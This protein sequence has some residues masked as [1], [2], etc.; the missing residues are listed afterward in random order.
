MAGLDDTGAPVA[1]GAFLD[2]EL[3]R[4]GKLPA[5]MA[6]ETG[7][8]ASTISK[9]RNGLQL[10]SRKQAQLIADFLKLPV[11]VVLDAAG[12]GAG[13]RDASVAQREAINL[14]I[15]IPDD[16]LPL[17]ILWLEALADERRWSRY[18]TA[19]SESVR[20]ASADRGPQ[21]GPEPEISPETADQEVPKR[22]HETQS[23]SG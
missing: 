14:I 1:F 16:I 20:F 19:I 2:R 4:L 10:P 6:R 11:S 13:F 15:A 8:Y 5:D 23:L 18:R 21:D 12:K 17:A 7:I 3:D 22:E 9:Y